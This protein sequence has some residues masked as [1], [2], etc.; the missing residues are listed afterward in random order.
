MSLYE[1]TL[2]YFY[3]L[4]EIPRVPMKE[5]KVRKWLKKWAK[6]HHWEYEMDTIGNILIRAPGKNNTTLLCLQ[7]HMDMVC[8]S[9]NKHDFEKKGITILDDGEKLHTE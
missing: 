2:Q 5:E 8:V 6:N 9:N 4:S 1:K 3:E 7:A